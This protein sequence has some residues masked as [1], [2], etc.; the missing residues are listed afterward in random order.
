MKRHPLSEPEIFCVYALCYVENNASIRAMAK[1]GLSQ[2]GS[3]RR[4]AVHPNIGSEPRDVISF[5]K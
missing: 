2:E 4:W 3:L 5:A 1:A